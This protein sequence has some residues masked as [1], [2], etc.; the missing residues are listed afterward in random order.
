MLFAD[1][2]L[3]MNILFERFHDILRTDN[4]YAKPELLTGG[5]FVQM[6]WIWARKAALKTESFAEIVKNSCIVKVE[7]K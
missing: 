2:M 5:K 1:K 7:S 3:A 6:W 4:I